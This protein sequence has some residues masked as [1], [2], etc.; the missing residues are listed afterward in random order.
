APVVTWGLSTGD[1]RAQG[2]ALDDEAR[3]SFTLTVPEGLDR[4]DGTPVPPGAHRVRP[5]LLGEHQ[6]A[7]VLAALTAALVAGCDP[8]SAAT[9]LDGAR[10]ESGQRMQALRAGGALVID[11][12]YNANPDSMRE[13]LKTLAHLGRGHRTIAVLGQMLELGEDTAALHD[14]IGRL[15]VRLNISQLYVVGDGAAAIH[16]GASLEG[17]FGGESE[18]LDSAEDAITVLRRTVMPGDVVLLKSSRDAG[19]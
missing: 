15:V 17:S 13:A 18:Y 9:A 12:A 14:Q 4:L 16:H 6:A 2:L 19:L 8:A 3:A 1:V 10:L 11:D 5:D 7:N